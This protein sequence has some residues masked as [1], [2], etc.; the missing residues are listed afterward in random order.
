MGGLLFACSPEKKETTLPEGV[1][2][3]LANMDTTISPGQ[4]FFKFVNGGWLS[5]TEIP[6][7]QGSWG[8]FHELAEQ[9]RA[10]VLEVLQA[11]AA[12]GEYPE[13]ADQQKAADFYAVGMDS[14]R[15]EKLGMTPLTPWLDKIDAM[16]TKDDIQAYIT[17]LQQYGS[18]GF[19]HLYAT[20]DMMNSDRMVLMVAEGGLGLP[21]RDYYF[22][23]DDR[24]KEIRNQYVAHV[25]RMLTMAGTAPD[26]A[27]A[28]AKAIMKLET[29]LAE[30][31]M[32]KENRR[33]RDK[34]YNKRSVK[35]LQEL[36]PA[37][38]W[39][40]FLQDVDIK[41]IDSVIVTNP[42]FFPAVQRI[43]NTTDLGTLKAYFKW[44]VINQ[45]APYL[46]HA[47]VQADFDFY[48]RVLQGVEEM[49]PRWKRVLGVTD[50]YLGEAIGKL[51]VDK[52]FPPEAKK[53]A[54]EMVEN[55][56][57][58]FAARINELTWMSDSTKKK[59]QDKLATFTVKIGYPDEWKDYA[60]LVVDDS[61]SYFDNM[62]NGRAFNTRRGF[63]KLGKPV[64]RKEWYM[65]PQTV[66]A[67]YNPP[68]NEI[69]FPAA[70]LQPPFYDYRADEALNYGGIGAV[71][72]HEISHGFDDQGS[73]FDGQGNR[74]D[75][76][77]EEDL[78]KFTARGKA[79][80]EQFDTYE[81]LPGVFV[82]GQYTL[83]ENIG[84]LGGVAVAY[85]GLERYLS[86]HGN[87]GL[88]D[89]YT[90]EQRFFLSWATIW[91]VKY[92]DESLRT[93]VKTNP[94]APGMYRA[95]GPLSNMPE[96]YQA[97]NVQ[98]GQGMYR[99]EAERVKIW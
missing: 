33:D 3:D 94:H 67:Y 48:S 9:T 32:T 23:D 27:K 31:T 60:G 78:E 66:N 24:S 35:Q 40:K 54:E 91:R 92:R 63:S 59:A 39:S 95:N 4:D 62:M 49:K 90:P 80:A 64:N 22:A 73:K 34:T 10:D 1:G 69:V 88:I 13:G 82:Q 96:F 61:A 85:D 25:A 19:F 20:N 26:K 17:T 42:D 44:G 50:R 84:D 86:Q 6:G 16:R 98:E 83:G 36:L 72:G 37:L 30:A 89:G 12:S 55:I 8:S 51:Y 70:I 99:A 15:A 56:K 52:H 81:A 29:A 45:A 38:A 11:A 65:T 53:K 58:A 97:F 77:T 87:P 28:Q 93:Q 57:L 68:F 75:W 7:D 41:D 43:V 2:L 71:I 18:G 76:W 14:M 47:W 46:D 79:L 5:Q 21:E 74:R